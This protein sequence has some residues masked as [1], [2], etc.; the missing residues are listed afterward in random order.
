MRPVIK[1]SLLPLIPT[2]AFSVCVLFLAG[3]GGWRREVNWAISSAIGTTLLLSV[4]AA[5]I[6]AFVSRSMVY[7]LDK[8]PARTVA[9]R[10]LFSAALAGF[11]PTGL[12]LCITV[13]VAV[14]VA[15]HEIGKFSTPWDAW[16]VISALSILL[17]WSTVGSLTSI[18]LRKNLAIPLA[19]FMPLV[20]MFLSPSVGSL[21]I[22]TPG[23]ATGTLNGLELSW[24][25]LI[26]ITV[27]CLFSIFVCFLAAYLSRGKERTAYY[28]LSAFVT[29]LI[30]ML[31][32]STTGTNVYKISGHRPDNCETLNG[33]EYCIW[34][35]NGST[36]H[37][38]AIKLSRSVDYLRSHLGATTTRFEQDSLGR[39]TPAH[40]GV[41]DLARIESA[42]ADEL[43]AIQSSTY[44]RGCENYGGG[45]TTSLKAA[46]ARTVLSFYLQSK[47][48]QAV[49]PGLS[50]RQ[51]QWLSGNEAK[52]W[53]ESTVS[54]L[55]SCSDLA[56]FTLPPPWDEW[57]MW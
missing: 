34:R 12:S 40:T 22:L 15:T 21:S 48:G 7:S 4:A 9:T 23:G 5:V 36:P 38:V 43:P 42:D 10:L 14:A 57:K 27:F 32:V 19:G 11:I 17:F 56:F 52:E 55:E 2:L 6:S 20:C 3:N 31:C 18:S 51:K 37:E 29:V 35:D 26:K 46:S 24:P 33:V 28:F 45:N 54:K 1:L 16:E 41:F 44:L 50:P 47:V 49:A 13:L 53:A 8:V 25:S 39:S 30:V